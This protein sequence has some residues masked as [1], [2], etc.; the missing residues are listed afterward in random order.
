MPLQTGHTQTI[1]SANIK[2]IIDSWKKTGKIGNIRPKNKKHA[3]KIAQAI[4][5]RKALESR[6]KNN[7]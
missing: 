4:A 5:Y 2:E 1:I 6:R 7:G 3:L